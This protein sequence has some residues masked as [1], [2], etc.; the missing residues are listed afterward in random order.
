[1]KLTDVSALVFAI[2]VEFVYTEKA[3]LLHRMDSTFLVEVIETKRAEKKKVCSLL[4][5]SDCLL[6]TGF[7]MCG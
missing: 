2:I 4:L 3:Y 1:M 5:H 6:H 7:E